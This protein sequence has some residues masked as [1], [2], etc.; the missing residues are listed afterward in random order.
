MFGA[1]TFTERTEVENSWV[2]D[3][4][5]GFPFSIVWKRTRLRQ[6]TVFI[7]LEPS[8]FTRGNLA[9]VFQLIGSKI[10]HADLLSITVYS[11]RKALRELIEVE[12]IPGVFDFRRN[13]KGREG[14]RQRYPTLSIEPIGYYRAVYNRS[15]GEEWF[16]YSP[17]PASER[18][19]W[20]N[21]RDG[22][23]ED[24]RRAMIEAVLQ[25]DIERLERLLTETAGGGLKRAGESLLKYLPRRNKERTVGVL[26]R[27]GEDVNMADSFGRTPLIGAASE[28]DSELVTV[29][30]KHGAQIEKKDKNG[31]TALLFAAR[32]QY[33]D[34]VDVLLQYE[35][36]IE[37]FDKYRVNALMWAATNGDFRSVVALLSKGANP[38]AASDIG[39]TPLFFC[40]PDSDNVEGIIHALV[41]KGADVNARDVDGWTALM[42]AAEQGQVKKVQALMAQEADVHLKNNSGKSAF[43]LAIA[44]DRAEVIR[45]LR[46]D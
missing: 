37:A 18:H 32:Y 24:R 25:G 30:L 19:V 11:D 35:L 22:G 33:P 38:N 21:L 44:R 28:G 27:F 10:S 20:I 9:R 45:L 42:R 16:R 13:E 46:N 23:R 3:K 1:P 5:L 8:Y 34:V 4:S 14:R 36:D 31:D 17:D 12:K 41:K 7:Y 15:G 2:M 26:I 29:L 40:D 6:H 43:D 39:A